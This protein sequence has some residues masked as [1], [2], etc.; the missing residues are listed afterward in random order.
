MING[1]S[2]ELLRA[3]KPENVR[4]DGVCLHD[5]E[6]LIKLNSSYCHPNLTSLTSTSNP[7][8]IFT[9]V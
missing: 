3:D 4:N 6:Q 2:A 5:P 8:N 9:N 7:S 1:F